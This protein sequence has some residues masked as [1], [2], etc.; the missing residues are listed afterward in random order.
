[1]TIATPA[2]T[3]SPARPLLLCAL[4]FGVQLTWAAV[5]GISLQAR[6]A[7][8]GGAHA[9]AQYSIITAGGG[10]VAAIVQLTVSPFSDRLRRAGN[11]RI[12]FYAVGSLLGAGALLALY[13][14]PSIPALFGA[15]VALEAGLNVAL[16]PYQ[17]ILPDTVSPARLGIAS[18]WMAGTQSAGNALG[19]VLAT[20][21]GATPA[22]GAVLAAALCVTCLLTCLHLRGVSL[23]PVAE[24]GAIVLS[25]TFADLFISRALVWLGFYTMLG[26]LFFY[27]RAVLPQHF[28]LDATAATGVCI[29]IFTLVGAAGAAAAAR[30]TDRLDERLVVTIGSGVVALAL[31]FLA[32]TAG[33]RSLELLL[34]SV[35]VSGLGWGIFLCAD[36]AFAC[37]LV[38]PRSLA[39]SMAVWNLAVVG[40]QMLAPVAATVLLAAT[41][42]TGTPA[43][44]AIVLALAAA[45]IAG[46]AA[47]IWRL[48]R[49]GAGK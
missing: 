41:K 47:W 16:G 7:Q 22:L 39:T 43:A 31:A 29:L 37:R 48:S 8:L 9:I 33:L 44:P 11:K 2:R 5:L 4:W 18:G 27:V 10:F 21:L 35:A 20:L 34:F 36:W 3:P 6:T 46:G 19:A 14:A 23:Q 15:F 49:S 32:A 38:P 17:A 13:A 40:A 42:A 26:Y 1:M 28:P 25:K 24:R 45:E 30:P 12:A